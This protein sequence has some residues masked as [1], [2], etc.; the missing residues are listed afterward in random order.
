MTAKTTYSQPWFAYDNEADRGYLGR[1]FYGRMWREKIT[2][3]PDTDCRTPIK[4]EKQDL[5]R[6][7]LLHKEGYMLKML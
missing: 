6:A 3:P 7:V 5:G 2:R 1:D 4:I